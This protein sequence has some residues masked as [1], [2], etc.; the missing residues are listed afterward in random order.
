MYESRSNC[1][2]IAWRPAAALLTAIA[3]AATARSPA[4]EADTPAPPSAPPT[5]SESLRA[6]LSA[7]RTLYTPGQ[8]ITL[9]FTL[10]NLSTVPVD[11]P[12][13]AWG[14]LDGWGLPG[15]ILFGTAGEPALTLAFG[16]ERPV[17]I[18]PPERPA[19]GSETGVE[20]LR[21]APHCSL[22]AE[23]DLRAIHRQVRYAGEYRIEWRP[24]SG[25]LGVQ[26]VS[27]RVEPRQDALMTTDFGKVTFSLFYEQAPRNVDNFLQLVRD[28]FYNGKAIHRI[29]PGALIQGGSPTGDSTGVRPDGKLVPAEFRDSPFETG[30]LAMALKGGDANSASCQFFVTLERLPELDGKYTIIGQARDEESLRTLNRIAELPTNR[31]GKPVRPV[32]IRFMTLVEAEEPATTRTDAVRP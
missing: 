1:P 19:A 20:I 6:E 24:L 28:K 23:V 17:A 7:S 15:A 12:F 22:G 18:A 13:E 21:L 2:R 14:Q 5:A 9:R 25:R 8:P 11:V 27:L 26:S 4:Q 10:V 31:E 32:I 16:G 3:L 29:V 30:T